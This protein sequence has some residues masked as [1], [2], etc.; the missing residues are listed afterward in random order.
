MHSA[1]MHCQHGLKKR[2]KVGGWPTCLCGTGVVGGLKLQH[3][4]VGH[5]LLGQLCQY[6]LGQSLPGRLQ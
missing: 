3:C 2:M 6:R 4:E 5:H 1:A